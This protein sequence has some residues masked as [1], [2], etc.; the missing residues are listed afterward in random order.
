MLN[1]LE[2][3]IKA[4]LAVESDHTSAEAN[5]ATRKQELIAVQGDPELAWAQLYLVIG[6]PERQS[7]ALHP[8]EPH[9]FPQQALERELVTAA[10]RSPDL[11]A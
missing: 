1:S 5:V 11:A 6:D 2:E 9:T 7:V 8:I 3:R 4:R 10:K